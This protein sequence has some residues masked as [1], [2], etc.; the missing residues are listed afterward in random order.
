VHAFAFRIEGYQ[1]PWHLVTSD[2]QLSAQE[3]LEVYAGRFTQEDAH[4][5]LKQH[6]GLGACQGRLKSVVLRTL[7]L[8]LVAMTMLRKLQEHLDAQRSEAWWPKP[9][10]YRQKQHGSLM[11]VKR[12]LGEAR[13]RFSQLPWES[14][15]LQEMAPTHDSAPKALHRAA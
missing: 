4:R 12:L 15:N 9:P 14:T 13:E 3:V 5:D 11:D 7:Q 10:W 8:R 6:L 1:K 2:L